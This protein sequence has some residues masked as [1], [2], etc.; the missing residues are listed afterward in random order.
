MPYLTHLYLSNNDLDV[1]PNSVCLRW[2]VTVLALLPHLL[3]SAQMATLENLQVLDMSHNKIRVVPREIHKL[4]RVRASI[5]KT[6]IA[7]YLH[8]IVVS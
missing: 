5:L 1:L 7:Q 6:G 8:L 4:K 2:I 3:S